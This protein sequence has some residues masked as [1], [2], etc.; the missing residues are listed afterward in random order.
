MSK[1]YLDENGLLYFWQK[2]KA[3]FALAT[4]TH[5]KSQITDFPTIPTKTSDLTNDS[6]FVADSS[7]VH[8]DNNYTSAEKTKLSGIA[9]GAEVNVQADWNETDTTSDAYIANKPTIPSGVTV[10]SALSSTSENPVQNK[11][12]NTALGEKVVGNGR[13]FY[14]TSSTG[15]STQNKVVTCSAYDALTEGDILLLKLSNANTHTAPYLNVNSKGAKQVSHRLYDE[16]GSST[17]VWSHIGGSS[18][19][20]MFVYE[21]NTWVFIGD[22]DTTYGT[23]TASTIETGTDTTAKVWTDKVLH[24]YIASAIETAQAGAATFQGTAPTSFAPTNY[25]SGY[26]WVVGTAGTYAGQTCEAG[27]MI[28]AT[29][30]GTTYSASDFDVI[31]TNLDITDISNSEIDAIVAS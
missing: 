18:R 5:T 4:H 8:T 20:D 10:D 27:D 19:I 21:S 28:F 9:T 22:E 29:A 16:E 15:A 24:D 13:V 2:L 30:D 14:G 26:Y 31:Q 25:K 23:G 12:I 3:V 1:K 6:N 7:Y 17:G 11:V